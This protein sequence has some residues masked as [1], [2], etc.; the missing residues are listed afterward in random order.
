MTP[1]RQFKGVPA[2]VVRK[3]E[4]KQ[5]VSHPFSFSPGVFD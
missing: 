4:G 3:A 2:D 5:F 1:L